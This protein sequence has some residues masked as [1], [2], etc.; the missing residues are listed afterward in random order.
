MNDLEER[1][2]A[3]LDARAG[4]H[5]TSPDAYAKVLARG[6]R[7]RLRRRAVLL[8]AAA[9][10]VAAVAA[11]TWSVAGPSAGDPEGTSVASAA[12][13]GSPL[14]RALREDPPTGQ[15]LT[16][17]HPEFPGTPIRV[18]YSR[19]GKG[20]PLRFCSARPTT[21][22]GDIA[23]RCVLAEP[24]D[25]EEAGRIGDTNGTLPLPS[26]IVT[27]GPAKAAVGSVSAT[28]GGRAFPGLVLHGR[29]M[30]LPVWV[31]R[32]SGSARTSPPQVS[33]DFTDEKGRR[34][35]RLDDVVAPACFKATAPEG[36]GVPLTGRLTAHL[37][38]ENCLVFWWDGQQAGVVGGDPAATLGA[39]LRRGKEPLAVWAGPG[40][41]VA[42]LWYGYTSAETV[43]VEVRTA[44]GG[45]ASV[46]TVE[47]FPGQGIR[48]FG[49]ELPPDADPPRDG[50]VYVGFDAGGAEIWRHRVPSSEERRT[51]GPR[52]TL[53]ATPTS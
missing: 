53:G 32:F 44:G 39:R 28:L 1:L 50:A 40:T 21:A 4:T 27:F 24:M 20:G 41:A 47:G 26:E 11:V 16:I 8:P 9:T 17:P 29:G 15:V 25:A 23:A 46:R 35:Q 5:D 30:P 34:L 13:P 42:G 45:R 6:E 14:G 43:R 33:Y 18:W 49:G 48:L 52:S 22:A 10:A 37:D 12:G 36:A 31:V 51:R 2:R 3:A 38:R 19:S 7:I